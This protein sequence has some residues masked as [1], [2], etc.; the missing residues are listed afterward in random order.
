MGMPA[1]VPAM[2]LST[3]AHSGLLL[4]L[5]GAC[6]GQGPRDRPLPAAPHR[7]AKEAF[8]RPDE[9][10]EFFLQKRV[11]VGETTVDPARYLKAVEAAA[12]L[13]SR[14]SPAS[15]PKYVATSWQSLG[16]DDGGGRTRALR[17]DPH[18]P[19]TIYAGSVAG[20]VWRSRD[21]GRWEPLG[22][23]LPNLAVSSLALPADEPGRI[24]AG[25]GEG[26]FNFD[27]LRGAG[28]FT[29]VDG[30]ASWRHLAATSG[31]DF[32]YVNDLVASPTVPGLLYAATRTGVWLS[33]DRGESWRRTLDPRS[34]SDATR[35]VTGGCTD[36]EVAAYAGRDLAFASCGNFAQAT[37]YR[38]LGAPALDWEPALSE[39]GMG[40]T[41]VA[42]AP[43]DPGVVYAVAAS[44]LPGP[45]QH[46]LHAVFRSDAA[47]APGSWS[48]RVRNTDT[49][50]LNTLLLS[51]PDE[52]LCAGA[53]TAR[54]Q[55]WYDL[56]I[57]VDPVDTERVWVGGVELFRSDDGGRT[58]GRANYWYLDD[59][60]AA[61][62]ADQHGLVFHPRYDGRTETRLYAYSDGGIHVTAEP[63]APTAT[64]RAHACPGSASLMRAP[65]WST[66]NAGYATTQF[67]HGDV[68]PDG[69]TWFG[70]AQDNGTLRGGM[71]PRRVLGGDGG[72]VA[73]DRRD[74]ATVYAA[75]TGISIRKST[76]GGERFVRAT[77]GIADV[78]LFIAPYVLDPNDGTILWTGGA[79]LWRSVDGALSWHA[80]SAGMPSDGGC[81]TERY[82][83]FA[84]APGDSG[85]VL[86]GTSCGTVYRSEAALAQTAADRWPG[87]R[88]RAG[89]VAALA[90]DPNRGD[91]VY[92]VYSTF[93]GCH[94]WRSDDHGATW[95]CVDGAAPAN[96]PDV[97]VNTLVVAPGDSNLI[98]IGS[99]I[100]VFVTSDGGR[101]WQRENAGFANVMTER[102]VLTPRGGASQEL[103]A[104]THGRGV[105]RTTLTLDRLFADQFD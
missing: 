101:R 4:V 86:A 67:F 64:T 66:L 61:A 105:Y 51:Y 42:V 16:P 65:R 71:A 88:P 37:V 43:S 81:G 27:A 59:V 102:L 5:L 54:G 34:A 28:V 50:L 76:D 93:G 22:D 10:H 15:G 58:F 73:V 11:A 77:T 19:D 35:T 45:Y 78:G 31:E 97:P 20:G 94:V 46:A 87:T 41:A 56:A 18:D 52:P 72:H 103:T 36:L 99:D 7:E 53:G 80:A 98:W 70:G 63:N 84:V 74:P 85:R 104:F 2:F 6:G 89:H 24:Y 1:P 68:A 8:D 32:A 12:T 38:S 40:R 90:Y 96:L 3:L 13:P 48:A 91:T 82:S 9:A 95:T 26:L 60:E 75:T 57:A 21:G 47:G 69:I 79:R 92:A 30:G 62:H 14:S 44:W 23:L 55:G 100:G 33:T 83:A 39:T 25:T 49:V 29:T 17:F